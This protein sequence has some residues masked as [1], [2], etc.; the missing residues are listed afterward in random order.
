VNK[1]SSGSG[2][3]D[4]S[5]WD[6]LRKAA[7]EVDVRGMVDRAGE[8]LGKVI[9]GVNDGPP[10]QRSAS[11]PKASFNDVG[12]LAEAK[13]EL[14]AV[15]VALSQPE[16]YQRWG[17]R[18]PKGVLL[19]GPPG[20][21]KTLLARCVAGQAQA[22][23]FHVR[24]VDVASMWY[25]QAERRLQDAFD[26]ARRQ[27]PAVVFLDEVDALTPPR[28]SS[29]E[30]SHRVVSTL[31][32]NLDGLR[33]LE[34]VVVLAATNTPDSV[35]AALM[36]PGR[37]DRLVEVPLPD[38]EA[39]AQILRVH[40]RRAERRAG[41]RLFA[42]SDWRRLVRATEGMSGAE[43]EETV[44]R[45]LEARVRLADLAE[46]RGP[47]GEDELLDAAGAFE[48]NKPGRAQRRQSRWWG[49]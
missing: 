27:T 3:G 11:I 24:A 17:A 10:V 21:G 40:M 38:A 36:R 48:W 42:D 2:N 29:H 32:E 43:L 13:R 26:R 9:G 37:L 34:G 23:F 47:I 1:G 20:T 14:E 41:R 35:D 4:G 6:S 12:G 5:L 25:G 39:R 33:P 30:A 31:L 18:P 22:A 49:T 46:A 19:Y 45:S 7:R 28:E 16:A 15:C 8:Q 44:R